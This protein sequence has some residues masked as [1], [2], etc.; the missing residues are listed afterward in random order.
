MNIIPSAEFV[1]PLE[2]VLFQPHD[3]VWNISQ[4]LLFLLLVLWG[5][6]F[7]AL[8]TK[9]VQQFLRPPLSLKFCDY[10]VIGKD[11]LRRNVFLG[12]LLEILSAWLGLA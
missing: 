9:R 2:F 1:L 11:E 10:A 6:D 5:S 7:L 8:K 4:P 12:T 3:G